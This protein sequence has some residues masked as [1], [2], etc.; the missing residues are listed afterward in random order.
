[1]NK[2]LSLMFIS[3]IISSNVYADES[4]KRFTDA[5]GNEI[6]CTVDSNG[7]LSCY[8]NN[9]DVVICANSDNG[10]ICSKD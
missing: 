10:Y 9:K 1:M 3:F 4:V 6:S 5:N 2:T 7:S 8:N